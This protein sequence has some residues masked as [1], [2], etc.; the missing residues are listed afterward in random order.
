MARTITEIHFS[1]DEL[2]AYGDRFQ[3]FLNELPNEIPRERV[4]EF[5]EKYRVLPAGTPYRGPWQN[6]RTPYSVEVMDNLSARS[7]VEETIWVKG[8]QI[9]ATAVAENFL[10]YI[11][12]HVPGPT[13]FVSAKEDLLRKW[14][15][16]RF[17]PMILSCRLENK[18]FKQH[19]LKGSRATGNQQ[20]SKEFPGGS[21]DFVSGQS[22]ANLRMDS[23]RYLILDEAGR[24]PWSIQG[25]GDP[26]EIAR[27]RTAN[28]L[29]RRK[30]FILSTAGTDGECRMWDL[31]KEGDQRRFFVKCERCDHRFLFKFPSEPAVFY[32][33]LSASEAKW[34]TKAGV[35][36]GPSIHFECPKCK[37]AHDEDKKYSLVI[38]AKWEPT[39]EAVK[40]ATRS[41][42]IGRLPVLMDKWE[43]LITIEIESANDPEKLQ[44]HHNQNAG[45]PY[46]EATQK[47]D[48]AKIY[49]LRGR[50]NSGEIPTDKVLF[51][52]V[53][54]DVQ[55]GEKNNP[56]KPPRVEIEVCGHGYGYRTWSLQYKVFPGKITDPYD[57]AWEAFYQFMAQGGL[58]CR[59]A[60]GL[61]MSPVII[62]IDSGDGNTETVVFDFC[63]RLHGAYPVKGAPELQKSAQGK[64]ADTVLDERGP[65]DRDRFRV[66]NKYDQSFVMILT[67]WYKNIL[68]RALKIQR[69]LDGE[70]RP[71][72]CEFPRDYPDRYFDMLVAEERRDD[73]SFWK[74]TSRANE[75]LDLRIYNMCAC[76]FWLY[77]ETQRVKR[78]MI[79]KGFTREEAEYTRSRHILDL[80]ARKAAR[81]NN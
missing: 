18:I 7:P 78:E 41:Y 64:K 63:S 74:P 51:L 1:Y 57:G 20:F 69:R 26:I 36:D 38:G 24:Y 53:A 8:S 66:L 40:K 67:N 55:A 35:L 19:T 72:F 11:I 77:L 61:V 75:S 54:A 81:K 3:A 12:K 10:G 9:G 76:D 52:T 6:W 50:Y 23:I 80:Y 42:Q 70:Q 30:V 31:Y 28:W 62:F 37:E 15:N 49:E 43:R 73:G 4:F 68:W 46:L 21:I 13:L 16:K 60:D 14:V 2:K 79:R 34:E 32:D 47:P 27:A 71:R 29:S 56:K 25:F 17:N 44:V 65:R 5:A 33:G 48:K 58:E 59:R 45:I 22:E 39:A